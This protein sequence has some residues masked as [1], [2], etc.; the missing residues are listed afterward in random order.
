[1]KNMGKAAPFRMG[2]LLRTF[3]V[4]SETFVAGEINEVTRLT[5]Q[6]PVIAALNRPGAG[7]AGEWPEGRT[8]GISYWRDI[9]KWRFGRIAKAHVSLLARNAGRTF[10]GLKT[11]GEGFTLGGRIK[12]AVLADFFLT[13]GVCH[14]HSHFGWEQAD[15]L[16]FL[17]R[18]CGLPYSL[19]LHA[20]D[21]FVA[22]EKLAERGARA[23]FVA[24]ISGYNRRVLVTRF[25]LPEEK[26]H[27]VH[28]GVDVRAF[29]PRPD[30]SWAQ[31]AAS[32]RGPGRVVCVGRMVPKKG[33]GIL[34]HALAILRAQ[35]VD[36]RAEFVGDGPKRHEL[37][38][39][40]GELGLT[41]RVLF[42]GAL[43]PE[44]TVARVGNG[45]IFALACMM[46]EDGD[47]DGI[48][49]ALMEA[50]AME[51]PVVSTRLSG[52][53]ELVAKGCGLLA[54]P[55][56]PASL[57]GRIRTLL[58]E[59]ELAQKLA[60]AGRARVEKHFSLTG[61][62]RRILALAMNCRVPAPAGDSRADGPVLA[63]GA[64]GA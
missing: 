53:P 6:A 28:C 22:P 45:H 17:K 51:K 27:V 41:E 30:Q 36:V 64:E 24:T 35:G 2:Y 21:I 60:R 54:R 62:A 7:Q 9:D 16:L 1:M 50:M 18:L 61:Q 58:D 14:L 12:A 10:V 31:S 47:M 49:V 42:T 11:P 15:T 44:Q 57:A 8:S 29:A 39:L 23:S 40:S 52:I 63:K 37:E 56:D 32:G 38:R 19:T 25:G 26:I 43:T 34:L 59:P 4:L 5:G 13:R 46:A 3:P 48:P 20:A 33:F 55:G